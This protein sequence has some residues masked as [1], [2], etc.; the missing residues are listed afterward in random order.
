MDFKKN[1]VQLKSVLMLS[2][3]TQI[4]LY[5]WLTFTWCSLDYC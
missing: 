4:S 5:A 3:C 1:S 2:T